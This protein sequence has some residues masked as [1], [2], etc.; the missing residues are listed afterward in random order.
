MWDAAAERFA[1]FHEW[2]FTGA[3]PPMLAEA[4]GRAEELVGAAKFAQTLA[5]PRTQQ[6]LNDGLTVYRLTGAGPSYRTLKRFPSS[7][8]PGLA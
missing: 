4:R 6:H 8:H 5:L 7:S 2:M 3:R 1:E